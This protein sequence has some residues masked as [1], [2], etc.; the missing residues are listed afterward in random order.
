MELSIE[1]K[2]LEIFK[3]VH[4]V[5]KDKTNAHFKYD[6]VSANKLMEVFHPLFA[7]YGLIILPNVENF[8]LDSSGV[9]KM[10]M[11]YK[12]VDA[13]NGTTLEVR[14]PGTEKG[15]KSS[16]KCLTGVYKYFFIQTFMLSTDDDPEAENEKPVPRKGL[17]DISTAAMSKAVA[18]H[19]PHEIPKENPWTH[20]IEGGK[21]ENQHKGKP[22][23]NFLDSNLRNAVTKSPDKFSKKDLEMIASALKY[24]D[25]LGLARDAYRAVQK[26]IGPTGAIK[27]DFDSDSIPY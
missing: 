7:K 5:E 20:E 24:P 19:F 12:I 11:C 15:D 3:E 13:A 8:E 2:L 14:I 1:Q 9:C 18:K 4:R 16:F 10:V 21:V 17:A 23:F 22:L 27:Q 26:L 6:Y 25:G